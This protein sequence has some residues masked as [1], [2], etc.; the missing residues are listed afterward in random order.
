MSHIKLLMESTNANIAALHYRGYGKSSGW[1]T[2]SGIRKDSE[3]FLE[4]VDGDPDLKQQKYFAFG[5]SLGKMFGK[6][7]KVG[8][9]VAI[10]LARRF[11]DRFQGLIIENTF[12]S[13]E[14]MVNAIYPKWTMYPHL[15]RFLWNHWKSDE[16]VKSLDLPILYLLGDKDEVVPPSHTEKL[17]Q[18]SKKASIV[19][20]P[21]G[22]HDNTFKQPGY[23]DKISQFVSK[24]V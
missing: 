6:C 15:T 23:S 9:A 17:Y 13:I 12:L 14:E 3:A 8:G 18:L 19:R 16:A 10:D 24:L 21:Y 5:H 7:L 1:S 20:F 2:E 11:P 22:M 4:F